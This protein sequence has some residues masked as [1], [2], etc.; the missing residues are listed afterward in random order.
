[1][2]RAYRAEHERLTTIRVGRGWAEHAVRTGWR[3]EHLG[4]LWVL[5]EHSLAVGAPIVAD[6]DVDVLDRFW[7]LRRCGTALHRELDLSGDEALPWLAV[8]ASTTDAPLL[9]DL[10]EAIHVGR[11][12]AGRPAAGRR[13]PGRL[14]MGRRPAA[15]DVR[16]APGGRVGAGPGGPGRR[17]GDPPA[18]RVLTRPGRRAGPGY[19]VPVIGE[20]LVELDGEPLAVRGGEVRLVD[21]VGVGLQPL[22]RRVRVLLEHRRLHRLGRVAGQLLLAGTRPAVAAAVA[23]AAVVLRRGAG[24]CGA[25][26]VVRGRGGDG[27]G[28][29]PA[30]DQPAADQGGGADPR[31]RRR[32][33]RAGRAG[34]GRV[35]R[36]P[37][38]ARPSFV[39]RLVA[40]LGWAPSGERSTADLAAAWENTP[41]DL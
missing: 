26:P 30:G 20:V 11:R 15:G 6:V 29:D 10:L 36:R 32:C 31:P 28:Q 13:A 16:R 8:V 27:A 21:P 18:A 12:L 33:A 3:P 2:V 38:S 22:D 1:M 9:A 7:F 14:G 24:R 17:A 4:Q 39:L 41:P 37:S 35:R 19:S 34:R 23:S 5:G 25:R 40:P